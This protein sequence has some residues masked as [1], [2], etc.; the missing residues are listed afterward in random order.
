MDL[1]KQGLLIRVSNRP[2]VAPIV[3]V[4]KLDG[5]IRICVDYIALNECIV[6][7]SFP[8]TAYR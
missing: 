4:L 7:G 1:F 3:M 5:F 8:V 6:K 2:Y